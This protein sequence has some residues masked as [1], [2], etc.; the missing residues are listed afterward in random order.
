MVERLT[1]A[2]LT[3]LPGGWALAADGKSIR[4]SFKFG[5]FRQAWGFMSQVALLAEAMDHHPEWSNIYNRVEITL[6][7]HDAGGVTKRDLKLAAAI[8]DIAG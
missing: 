7:T 5:N 8:D 2:E 3:A 1:A 6:T 4:Q